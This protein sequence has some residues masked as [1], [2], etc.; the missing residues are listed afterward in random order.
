MGEA[1]SLTKKNICRNHSLEDFAQLEE[2]T[3]VVALWLFYVL[4]GGID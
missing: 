1:L 2:I 3:E 4:Q